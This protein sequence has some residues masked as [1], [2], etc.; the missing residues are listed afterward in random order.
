MKLVTRNINKPNY[1]K[2]L[3]TLWC[4]LIWYLIQVRIIDETFGL[5]LQSNY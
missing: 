4:H 2:V 1:V 5:T 3:F